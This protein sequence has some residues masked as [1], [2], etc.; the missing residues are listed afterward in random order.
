MH[1]PKGK[2]L[3]FNKKSDKMILMGY[4]ET[5]TVTNDVVIEETKE[6]VLLPKKEN[7]NSVGVQQVIEDE[8]QLFG[9]TKFKYRI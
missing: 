2:R 6:E 5:T 7:L 3:K 1:I 4:I 8:E 9:L